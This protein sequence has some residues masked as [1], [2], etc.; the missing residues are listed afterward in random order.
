[1]CNNNHAHD[2]TTITYAA[3]TAG[4]AFDLISINGG[5]DNAYR[6]H[7]G[8]DRTF[9]AVHIP[10]FHRED[11]DSPYLPVTQI[12]NGTNTTA[13]NAFG[14]TSEGVALYS[15]NTTLTTVTFAAESQL[16][17]IG[18]SAFSRC[19]SLT[20]IT[21][22]AS[23]RSISSFAFS[24]CSSLA[25]VTFAANSRLQAISSYAFQNCTGL[26]SITI[27]AGVTSIG[28]SAF[29]DCIGLAGIT[30]A[31]GSQ[32]TTINRQAFS[33]CTSLTSITIP[34][35]VTEIG[36]SA[37][38]YCTSLASVTFEGT[39]DM[40]YASSFDGDLVEKYMDLDYGGI[41]TYTRTPPGT[42]WTKQ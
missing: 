1:V 22:P 8:G 40:G 13:D 28:E 39:V 25:S 37:F 31:A 21:I 15:P 12:R 3:G 9:A 29:Y 35:G 11:A 4:L 27:P 23:V 33:G 41:G 24:V 36:S 18:G 42:V 30:F 17:T 16:T 2:E 32:L 6:V 19:T 38:N 7:N 34:A 5:T 14:G 26:A 20:S 10:A